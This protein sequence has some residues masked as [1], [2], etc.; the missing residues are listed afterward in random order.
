MAEAVVTMRL[1]FRAHVVFVLTVWLLRI[2]RACR[3]S[4]KRC[5]A[6]IERSAAWIEAHGLVYV[7]RRRRRV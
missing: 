5:D 4:P 2:M 1:R 7:V 6:L 3:V